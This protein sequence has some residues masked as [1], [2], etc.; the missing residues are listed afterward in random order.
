MSESATDS[1]VPTEAPV[2][3]VIDR[4]RCEG[5]ADCVRVCPFGVFRVESVSPSDKAGLG[6]FARLKLFMHGG[7]QAYVQEASC[8]GC[9]LCVSACPEKAIVLQR[10]A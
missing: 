7:K 5:K 8:H 4:E 6:T 2:Q 1:C 10:A 3:P 9:G